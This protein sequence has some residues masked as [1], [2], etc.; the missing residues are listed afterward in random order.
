M[1]ELVKSSTLVMYPRNGTGV[2]IPPPALNALV[3][4]STRKMELL[5]T[6]KSFLLRGV[7]VVAS[8]AHNLKV[9]GS[10]PVPATN[11][12]GCSSIW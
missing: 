4:K 8:Q 7:A 5:K 11:T 9:I 6:I 2:Q 10:N 12:S 1:A 3:V